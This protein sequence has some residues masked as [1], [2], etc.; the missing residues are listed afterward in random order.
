MIKFYIIF[1]YLLCKLLNML[2]HG[3]PWASSVIQ[4]PGGKATAL[5]LAS[6]EDPASW[7]K[8]LSTAQRD[9]L[10]EKGPHK[11]DLHYEFPK[12]IAGRK[13]SNCYEH[14]LSNG[15]VMRRKCLV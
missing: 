9:F 1:L 10:V 5:M 7:P 4:I 11:F 13:F 15:T 14:K 3:I 6:S 12:D 2:R 8:R